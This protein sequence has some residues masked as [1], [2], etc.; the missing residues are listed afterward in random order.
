MEAAAVSA[1]IDPCLPPSSW[2]EHRSSTDADAAAAAPTSATAQEMRLQELT[3]EEGVHGG[4][5][6]SP[7]HRVQ[8]IAHEGVLMDLRGA[9]DEVFIGNSPELQETGEGVVT[10]GG[11]GEGVRA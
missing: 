9:S 8:S 3:L 2:I 10:R 4:S 7:A 1:P 11:R 5:A 6:D